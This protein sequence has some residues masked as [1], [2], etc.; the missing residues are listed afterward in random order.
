MR[1]RLL[2]S[3]I[4]GRSVRTFK[5]ASFI[6][7]LAVPLVNLTSSVSSQSPAKSSK[8]HPARV[9]PSSPPVP[10]CMAP[11][12]QTIYA[13]TIGLPEIAKGRI[14]F[15]SRVDVV[16]EV[17]PTF[18]TEEGIGISGAVVQVQPAEIRYV[19]IASL[20]PPTQ[21][22]R[23]RW[24]GMS[25]SYSGKVFDIWAQIT[26]LGALNSGS[27]DVTFSVLNGRGSDTQ[28]AVWWMPR[29]GRVVI[30]L[31]NSS[32][33]SIQTQLEY[34][35]GDSQAVN[36]A[37]YATE[38]VRL[39][40]GSRKSARGSHDSGGESVRLTTTG[41]A[42]SLKAA[43]LIMAPDSRLVSSMR[44][45]DINSTVQQHLFSTNLRLRGYLPHIV[46]KN[47]S[48]A[49]V[50]AQPR[51]RPT[52]GEGGNPVELPAITLAPGEITELN[53]DPLM[54]IA[55]GRPDLDSVS[56]QIVNSGSP[57]SLIGAIFG[58][59]QE[60]GVTY[61]VPLRDS[62]INRANGG[63][64]PWRIDGDFSTVASVTNVG[65]KPSRFIAEIYYSGGR[66]L[67]GHRDLA[68]GETASFDL[69]KIRDTRTPDANGDLL[70]PSLTSGQFRW[71]WYPG[72]N[73]P[74][75]IGR[76]AMTSVTKG[77]SASYSCMPN[78]GA[79]GPEYLIDGNTTTSVYGYETMG[80]KERW[81]GASGGYND[82]NTNLS[83][84]TVENSSVANLGYVS[85]GWHDVNGLSAGDTYWWWDYW[86][87]YEYDDGFDCRYAQEQYTGSEETQVLPAPDRLKVVSDTGQVALAACPSIITRSIVYQVLDTNG[88]PVNRTLRA[89]E[90][91]ANQTTN[92]CGN[93]QPPPSSCGP[94]NIAG[95]IG[96]TLS[97]TCNGQSGAQ[98]NPFCGFT[99]TQ[100]ISTC[101]TSGNIELSFASHNIKANQVLVNT[102]TQFPLNT[103]LPK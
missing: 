13:P 39:H 2:K 37:P 22:W 11:T 10:P 48:P 38:Y 41:P 20:L 44:F 24:G 90:A 98:S 21:R 30:A 92:T 87:G 52:I 64:Y 73:A 63:A 4:L 6:L 75:M 55:A 72:P 82:F 78:C 97:I 31:G 56:V 80:T 76:A 71:H 61:D 100:T 23:V 57:G 94:T 17:Q 32:D 12:L 70:P 36:I 49:N 59:D 99:Q 84:S 89:K 5:V 40:P 28:E 26:L 79:H 19:E 16:T 8:P 95:Q 74:R 85:D 50:T 101:S 86:Y 34:S 27:S 9:S 33:T 42:G 88:A 47:T 77:I 60:S 103:I 81:Y 53:L 25:L 96:D 14:V 102:T 43:G 18:Y 7:L 45:Y 69:R 68:V 35:G 65:D 51:F 83:G 15:N 91:F 67:F 66:Y 1:S 58:V 93:G 54:A 62:G 46:L 29:G 3:S